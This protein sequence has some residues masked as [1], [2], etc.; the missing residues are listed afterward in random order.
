MVG[1]KTERGELAVSTT[2]GRKFFDEHMAYIASKDVDGLVDD[3][4]TDDAVLVSPFDILDVPPPHIVRGNQ[5]LKDFFKRYLDWQGEI[6]LES[7]Y[8]F[9]ELDDSICFHAIVNSHT[10]RWLVGDGWKLQDGKI[11]RHYSFA[12][13]LG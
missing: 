3:Q 11:D 12:Y 9:A 1:G 4:Y 10:G 6:N 2:P 13:K 5:A 7:L 8:N